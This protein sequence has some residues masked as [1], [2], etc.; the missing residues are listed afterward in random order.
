MN[1]LFL[2][3]MTLDQAQA[4]VLII[5]AVITALTGVCGLIVSTVNSIRLGRTELKVDAQA[6]VNQ[7]IER[8]TDGALSVA[9]EA[10]QIEK[11]RSKQL[12]EFIRGSPGLEV[13]LETKQTEQ[14]PPPLPTDLLLQRLGDAASPPP[15]TATA[16]TPE[17][18]AKTE[19]APKP[20]PVSTPL[21]AP[22]IPLPKPKKPKKP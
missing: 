16:P 2:A 17:P 7:K 13:P 19:P 22:P 12:E 20:A 18:I 6:V 11:A 21:P 1:H 10:L 15:A 5:G 4:W 3:T 8:S 9:K 14:K